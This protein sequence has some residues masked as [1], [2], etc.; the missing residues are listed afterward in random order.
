MSLLNRW[1][2]EKISTWAV[3]LRK[4]EIAHEYWQKMLADKPN[5]ARV[6]AM[7][8]H[9]RVLEGNEAEAISTYEKILLINP[10][11]SVSLFNFGYLLQKHG[12]HQRAIKLFK[13]AIEINPKLDQAWFGQGLSY[14]ALQD[15]AAAIP[16]FKSTNKLQPMSP[17]GYYELAKAQHRTNDLNACEKTMRRLKDFDPKVAAQLEDETGIQIGIDRWWARAK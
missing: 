5:D 6:L 11:D 15:D 8:A 14:V 10:K 17:H 2:W 4:P 13:N 12:E 9:Q 7:I 1:Y 3:V 16:C